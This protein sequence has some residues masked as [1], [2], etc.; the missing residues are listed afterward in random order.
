[1][2]AQ[3]HTPEEL[4]Q[5]LDEAT[6]HLGKLLFEAALDYDRAVSL[7]G[8]TVRN[9]PANVP[10]LYYYGQAIR[11]QVEYNTLQRAEEALSTYLEKGAPLGHET[12]VRQFLEARE[13]STG[14]TL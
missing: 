11:A 9:D 6:Y 10:A 7:L 12:E 3:T 1:M 8:E 13:S 14:T 4:Q 5:I 2:L